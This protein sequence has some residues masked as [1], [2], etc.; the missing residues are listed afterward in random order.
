[1]Q[2]LLKGVF[3]Q[4][5]SET[6]AYSDEISSCIEKTVSKLI[7]QDTNINKP[8]M[9]L[10]KIQSGKTN[11]FIGIIALAFDNDYDVAVVLTKGT[12]A[13]AN[14]TFKRLR[15]EFKYFIDNDFLTVYDIMSLPPKLTLYHLKKKLIFVV[16]KED[17]NLNTLM[18]IFSKYPILL[19]KKVLIIDD[20][21]DLAS[22]GFR[23]S[24]EEGIK[25]NVIAKQI[26]NF[27]E[28]LK[29][30]SSFLQVTATPYSLYLQPETLEIKSE[31]FEPV[32]PA[33]TVLVPI[34]N[35]YIGGEF[36]F[37]ESENENSIAYYLHVEVPDIELRVLGKEDG[38]Y[39][40]N[41]LSTPNLKVFREAI[42]NFIVGGCIRR[43]QD[44]KKKFS[45]IVH[46]ETS[47]AKHE[48]QYKLTNSLIT[49]LTDCQQNEP[50][51]L[52][53]FVQESYNTFIDSIQLHGSELPP[54]DEVYNEVEA[55]L[56]SEFL[57]LNKVNSDNEIN[58]LLDE[59]G[60]LRLD[61]PLNIFI[62]GQILDRGLTIENLIGFFYGRNPQ[63]FQQD[64]VLQHSRMYG[65][66]SKDD[67]TVTRLYTSNRIYQAMKRMNDFDEALREAFEKGLNK[68]V[69]FI[70]KDAKNLIIPC[71]PNKILLT[72]TVTLK[73]GKRHLPKGFQTDAKT[74]IAKIIEQIDKLI[75]SE[76]TQDFP[77]VISPY[78]VNF[79]EAEEIIR[80][81]EKTLVFD[82]G[83]EW[84]LKAFLSNMEYLSFK[85]ENV[86]QR[87]K[88]WF[89]VRANRNMSRKRA[90]GK[91]EDAPDTPKG[92][93]GE[94]KIARE[95][96]VN[97]PALILL[98]QNGKE[99]KGWR[100]HPFW[101]PVLVAPQNM[102]PVV[103]ASETAD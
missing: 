40:T 103:F 6:N 21:A 74:K 97:I 42:I 25:I 49:K 76:K 47:K 93:E 71:S 22:I 80:L 75:F 9:L 30:T 66:R 5:L 79:K 23:K 48:W 84:D 16:K 63:R 57:V 50:S 53:A 29:S 14:Q 4:K 38:R 15:R 52:K 68:E 65:P 89:I 91:F 35:Q 39:L 102:H 27:R 12:I 11:T 73:P 46:T 72:N 83:Y 7:E 94:L 88:I 56:E 13:L 28:K 101:W 26:S 10:G 19:V 86:N 3:Y 64:T 100:G 99:E 92:E 87:G 85:A 37:G 17:D 44:N 33:F 36:Y 78:T 70:R 41:I 24:K 81:I 69:V 51:L 2:T 58:P 32:K 43:L 62:G 18:K 90:D 77:K 98:R 54:F 61:N 55:A 67:L 82:P 59:M 60:Q 96:A 95:T 1:M 34:H 31:L 45:F 8:G 20:E